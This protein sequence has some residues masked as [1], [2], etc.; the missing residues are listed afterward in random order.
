GH[1]V[2]AYGLGVTAL[3][4]HGGCNLRYDDTNP[5]KEDMEYVD[6]I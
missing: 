5:V 3:K 4:Y 6:S 1:E 2:Q